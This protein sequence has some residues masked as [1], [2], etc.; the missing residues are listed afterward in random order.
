MPQYPRVSRLTFPLSAAALLAPL[1]LGAQSQ[2]PPVVEASPPADVAPPVVEDVPP[3]PEPADQTEVDKAVPRSSAAEPPPR[4]RVSAAGPGSSAPPPAPAPTPSAPTA[5]GA[6]PVRTAPAAPSPARPVVVVDGPPIV[7]GPAELAR[8][9]LS[10]RAPAPIS[11][12]PPVVEPPR[13]VA[14]PWTLARA[15]PWLIA[16]LLIGSSLALILVR[17][18]RRIL[19]RERVAEPPDPEAPQVLVRRTG[20]GAA[21]R[22]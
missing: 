7:T 18:R 16:G 19:Y 4:S 6:A 2:A 15:I 12:A 20:T 11:H 14:E 1:P 8:P 13:V 22:G 3:A 10:P 5:P 17:R 21:R 9:G